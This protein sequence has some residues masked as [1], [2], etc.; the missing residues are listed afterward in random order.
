MDCGIDIIALTRNN[1]FHAFQCKYRS[2]RSRVT[3][4]SLATFAGLLAVSGPWESSLVMTNC[5]NL[6]KLVAHNLNRLT[7]L[8][9]TSMPREHWL[10]IAGQYINRPVSEIPLFKPSS[11]ADL[12]SAR[13]RY[14]EGAINQSTV[15]TNSNTSSTSQ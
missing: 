6:T 12:R 14:F 1:T 13:L 2:R 4:G 5:S 15:S 7:K 10:F 9:F 11:V 8:N 3:W